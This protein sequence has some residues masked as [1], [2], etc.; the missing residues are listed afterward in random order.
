MWPIQLAFPRFTVRVGYSSPLWLSVILLHFSHDQSNWSSPSFSSTTFQ[1]FP[2][3]SDLLSEL[4][5]FQ[6]QT[7]LCSKYSTL[8]VSCVVVCGGMLPCVTGH[9]QGRRYKH[10]KREG[11]GKA[12]PAPTTRAYR[13]SRPIAPFILNLSSTLRWVINFTPRPLYPLEQNT[14]LARMDP[15]NRSAWCVE[16]KSLL[17]L[18][19]VKPR[20]VQPVL[21]AIPTPMN[22]LET[23]RV[24]LCV[25]YCSKVAMI[26]NII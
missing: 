16:E 7:T 12:W 6:H 1:N 4:S 22:R 13:S 26:R 14:G 11:K 3:I 2:R 15:K 19:R 25:I 24:S 20:I 9:K 17:P 18:Y 21:Y 5:Q 23:I 10:E 8:L